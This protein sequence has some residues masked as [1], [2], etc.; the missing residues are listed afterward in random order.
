M[1]GWVPAVGLVL[2]IWLVIW[3]LNHRDRRR[4][5]VQ[6]Q[7]WE[8]ERAIWLETLSEAQREALQQARQQQAEIHQEARRRL[9][10][11]EEETDA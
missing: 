10:L 2:V 9:G 1:L 11:P 5:E 8:M 4:R 6:Q 3:W 7:I